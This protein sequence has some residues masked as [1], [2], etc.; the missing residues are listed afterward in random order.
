VIAYW[1]LMS[2]RFRALLQYR[3]AALAGFGTQLF[4]GLIRV[5]IF[6]AFYVSSIVAQPM[7]L[8]DVV[9]Y[10]WLG[11]AFLVFLPWNT[12]RDIQ[13]MIRS[14]AVSYELLR[15]LDLYGSWFSR[16][17][18][19]RT[20]PAVLRMVPLL[21]IAWLFLDM[22]APESPQA[23]GAFVLA[24]FGAL[25]LSCAITSLLNISLLWTISG[26]GVTNLV[27]AAVMVFSGM[28]VPIPLFP[29]WAQTFLRVLP[30]GGLV[31][32][33]F[34]LYVGHIPVSD[35]PVYLAHQLGWTLALVLLGRW[36]LSRGVRRLVI[37]GG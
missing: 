26:D 21:V 3:A 12:D 22:Q 15:P 16:A 33:P 17:L 20:A 7:A 19:L 27:P 1:S 35:L 6:E 13:L 5:M 8:E 29:D 32:T 36:T 2:A 11:Q 9:T 25:L 18:A 14:G 4:W 31:D 34:R 23:A 28:I 24:M 37:Q 30:F 10:V